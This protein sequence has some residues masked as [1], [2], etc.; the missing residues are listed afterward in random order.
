[1]YGRG[2]TAFFLSAP[3]ETL[4]AAITIHVSR[5]WKASRRNWIKAQGETFP[6]GKLN[7]GRASQAWRSESRIQAAVDLPR[8]KWNRKGN[9]YAASVLRAEQYNFYRWNYNFIIIDSFLHTCWRYRHAFIKNNCTRNFYICTRT[10]GKG[11]S[12]ISMK[13]LAF[14]YTYHRHLRISVDRIRRYRN[15]CFIEI[16]K[17]SLWHVRTSKRPATGS[18]GLRG[19]GRSTSKVTV[20][21]ATV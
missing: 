11:T 14:I 10:T 6:R 4:I 21:A 1:M 2:R 12:S 7:E 5:Q 15:I 3:Q 18:T 16:F 19:C 8:D 17:L 13:N 20:A 9:S